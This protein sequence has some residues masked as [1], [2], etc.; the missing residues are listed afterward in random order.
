MIYDGGTMQTLRLFADVARCHSFSEAARLHGVTQS[1][2]SQ[3]ISQL[4][5]RLGATLFDRSVRPLELTQAGRVFLEGCQ[6]LIERY[7]E[8]EHRV[9]GLGE[10]EAGTVR[11]AA[12]YSAGIELLEQVRERFEAD[13]PRI[14]VQISYDHPEAVHEAV[15]EMD[16]DMGI[17][18]YPQRWRG[19]GVIPLRDEAM[20]VVCS[21]THPLAGKRGVV[22]VAELAGR[23]MVAF[24]AALPVGRRIRR[25]LRD[26]DVSVRVVSSFD[27]LDT[28]KNVVAVT[29]AF[30]I[31]PRRTVVRETEARALRA[32]LLAPRLVRPVGII[33]RQRHR[34]GAAFS[35]AARLFAESLTRHAGPDGD[36]PEVVTR[37]EGDAP[38]P[39]PSV[40]GGGSNGSPS[41]QRSGSGAGKVGGKVAGETQLAGGQA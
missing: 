25:Y 28:I 10:A 8:L 15:R 34:Q 20:A 31:L 26:N 12:I 14:N 32:R 21:P 9:A 7:D 29:G 3:R 35:S 5:K 2:A 13:H 39:G 30:A 36:A 24:D 27:N 17:V 22:E 41:S 1:A 40:E 18:S 6:S 23:E 37:V 19:V 38:S 11:V 33:Y 4:E 16:C